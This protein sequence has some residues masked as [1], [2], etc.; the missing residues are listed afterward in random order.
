M[1]LYSNQR[2]FLFKKLSQIIDFN[3]DF[4]K[5]HRLHP[6]ASWIK[7]FSNYS[8]I[9]KTW[10]NQLTSVTLRITLIKND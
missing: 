3:Q 4:A 10:V 7:N 5:N 1:Q 6:A 9:T 8:S 2:E